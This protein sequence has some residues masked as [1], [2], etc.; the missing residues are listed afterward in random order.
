MAYGRNIEK[1]ILVDNLSRF[2]GIGYW[3][4]L[5]KGNMVEIQ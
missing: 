2:F 3:W 4:I 5:R 1:L